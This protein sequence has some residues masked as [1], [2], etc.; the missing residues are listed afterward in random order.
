MTKDKKTNLLKGAM[1]AAL[2]SVAA[3][4]PA[5]AKEERTPVGHIT[6]NFNAD[7][8]AGDTDATISVSV[9]D[10]NCS[11]ESADF[12]NEQEYWAGFQQTV[13]VIFQNQQKV[14]SL[15]MEIR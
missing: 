4:F 5:S 11:V 9:E 7:V 10:G 1:F 15:L 14:L 12:I 13:T 6:L 2:L 8:Q 3:S